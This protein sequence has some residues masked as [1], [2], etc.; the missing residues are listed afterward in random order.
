MCGRA[1]R[2]GSVPAAVIKYAVL[3]KAMWFL[4][5]AGLVLSIVWA[6]L[7]DVGPQ[8]GTMDG[9]T[10]DGLTRLE[11]LCAD[12]SKDCLSTL[13]DL[14]ELAPDGALEDLIG[15][16]EKPEKPKAPSAG[17]APKKP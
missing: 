1:W 2:F 15:A 11:K 8:I 13:S 7:P 3:D 10:K 16:Q 14:N 17:R 6:F 4:M 9:L 5:R 12:H